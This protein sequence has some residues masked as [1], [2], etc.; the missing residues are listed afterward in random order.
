MPRASVGSGTNANLKSNAYLGYR[1]EESAPSSEALILS[2]V[3]HATNSA[4]R[5]VSHTCTI[6]DLTHARA[7][8]LIPDWQRSEV[9][10]SNRKRLLLDSVMRRW[11]LPKLI[12]SETGADDFYVLDGQQRRATVLGF[13]DGFA[14][15]SPATVRNLG[16]SSDKYARLTDLQRS[17]FNGFQ[18]Q[19]D[20]IH[21]A[22]EWELREYFLRLQQGLPLN[23]REKLNATRGGLRDFCADL[24]ARHPFFAH[25]TTPLTLSS[26]HRQEYLDVTSKVIAIAIE[27]LG[28]SLRSSDLKKLFENHADFSSKSSVAVHIEAT[29]SFV[30]RAFPSL[31]PEFRDRSFVQSVVT[32]AS[33]LVAGGHSDGHEEEFRD[34]VR[35]FHAGLTQYGKAQ[36]YK[37]T[38]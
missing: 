12:F 30:A 18:I 10:A 24:I 11:P 28:A 35:R 2:Y 31:S 38:A 1:T 32:L 17:S 3:W 36:Q 8:H 20:T 37:N 4:M 7:H 16:L 21:N 19:Y 27:G 6:G 33:Q 25:D 22:S 15:L 5:M 14:T 26:I 29:L 13:R 34:F 9:W 23:S